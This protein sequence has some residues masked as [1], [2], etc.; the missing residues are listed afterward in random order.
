VIVES[1]NQFYHEAVVNLRPDNAVCEYIFFPSV[2]VRMP[3]FG[4][5]WF[6]EDFTEPRTRLQVQFR[7]SVEL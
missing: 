7:K 6:F 1:M 5:V 3:K 4:L 2:K